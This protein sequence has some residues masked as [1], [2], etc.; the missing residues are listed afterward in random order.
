[1]RLFNWNN[2]QFFAALARG[3]TP[4]AAARILKVDHNTVRRRVHS[5]EQDLGV[6]LFEKNGDRYALTTHGEQLLK[7]VERM[8]QMMATMGDEIVGANASLS[9]IVRVGMPDGAGAFF[10]S[11]RLPKL[12][13][14]YPKLNIELYL[15]S[16]KFDF[17]RREV[18]M[19]VVIGRPME[20]PVVITKLVDMTMRLYASKSYLAAHPPILKP[21]DLVGHEFAGGIHELDFGPALNK[22]IV[23]NDAFRPRLRSSSALAALK[24]VSAGGGLGF[25]VDALTQGEPDLVTVLGD[26][27][28]L[29]RELWLA[30]RSDMKDVARI[31]VVANFIKQEFAASKHLFGSA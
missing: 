6:T 10:L 23:E 15:G 17:S 21:I 19:A 16:Q 2:L 28:M 13:N 1:M 27:V 18:D 11:P 22:L 25:F 5:L 30:I 9:G 31:N 24:S 3:G 14:Q 8:E 29:E 4:L 26:Q 20:G 12:A 7:L